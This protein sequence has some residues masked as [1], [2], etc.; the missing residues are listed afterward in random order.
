MISG[1]DTREDLVGTMMAHDSDLVIL[2]IGTVRRIILKVSLVDLFSPYSRLQIEVNIVVVIIL[3]RVV[4][5][6]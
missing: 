4:V 1:H 5:S 6:V 2:N 3:V